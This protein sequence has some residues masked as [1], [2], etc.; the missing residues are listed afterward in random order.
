[1]HKNMTYPTGRP[2]ASALLSLCVLS[3][4]LGSQLLQQGAV[5]HAPQKL[6]VAAVVG[7][8]RAPVSD[9]VSGNFMDFSKALPFLSK[10]TRTQTYQAVSFTSQQMPGGDAAL[11]KDIFA[12]QADGKMREAD[13]LIAGLEDRRL[14]GHVL[15][16]RYAHPSYKTS[17][18]ELRAWMDKYAAQPG[19]DRIYKMAS[20]R[21]PAGY[22]GSLKK[23]QDNGGFSGGPDALVS[24]G[25]TYA[26]PRD[27]TSAEQSRTRSARGAIMSLVMDGRMDAALKRLQT[28]GAKT[29]DTVEYDSLRANIA[30]AY[31]YQGKMTTAYQLAVASAHRSNKFAPLAGWV[32]GM[33]SWQGHRYK[34]A[35]KF[36]EMTGASEYSSGWMSAAGSYWAAR[37]HMRL[38]DVRQVSAWL[39]HASQHPRTFYGLIATRTLGRDFDFNWHVPTFTKAYYDALMSTPAGSR[40]IALVAANQQHRAENELLH[41][42]VSE[43]GMRDAVLAYAGYADLPALA[44]KLGNSMS[45]GED[46]KMYDAALY[47]RTSFE[48]ENGYKVDPALI[49]AIARQESRFDPAAKSSAG[50]LGLM[51]IMPSTAAFVVRDLRDVNREYALKDPQTNINI[52]QK[53][54]QTLLKDPAVKGD[55]LKLLVAYNA[56]P[57]NLSRWNRQW[58]EISDPLM[59]I[60]LIPSAQTRAYVERVLSNYWIYR[61]R[62]SAPTPTLDALASGK[63]AL[64]AADTG[65]GTF[66]IASR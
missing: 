16:Q 41:L 54:I 20:S 46:G 31:M 15:Y 7:Q 25:K 14:M 33:T 1:M 2:Q 26:S 27:R 50:A 65:D 61:L 59:F 48:P 55:I 6:V 58:D 44:M 10:S 51:Q 57:G 35:A 24:S 60:E 36:F 63:P 52:A 40:A 53:Y 23:P 32:A 5:I 11:Y 39:G 37:S 47:P 28:E 17:F 19:A 45:G 9:S 13:K 3:V 4:M 22:A 42:D 34:E 38:G 18:N 12:L 30:A 62:E 8:E 29:F 56:G 64:Y 49:N 66:S 21:V 43:P